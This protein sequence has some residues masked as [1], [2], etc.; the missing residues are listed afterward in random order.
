M[1]NND[2][3]KID[4]VNWSLLKHLR[5]SGLAY[6]HALQNPREDTEALALGRLTHTLVFEPALFASEYVIWEGGTRRGK[7]WEA[8]KAENEGR[9]IFK[10]DEIDTAVQMAEAVKRHP[11][12]QPYLDGGE[13]EATIQWTDDSTGLKCKARP[14][15]LQPHR[16]ALVDLKTT[17]S[18]EARYFGNAAARFGYHCQ[19]AH[20]QAGVRA[21]L[22]WSP[23]V[24][25]LV[26]V[27]KVAPYD[28]AVFRLMEDDLYAGASEVAELLQKLRAYTDAQTWP[29]RYVEEQALQLPA[30]LFLDDEEVD[31][32]GLGLSVEG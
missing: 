26:A 7:E 2:Y 21:A 22:G 23:E 4:G 16:R 19:L 11:L 13:F 29:G 31:A 5:D 12:V 15:W 32:D 17:R 3:S 14:D 10:P 8:F 20:Y 25:A 6:Q 18:I 28:V 27:E 24:V 30:W 9:T 1:P